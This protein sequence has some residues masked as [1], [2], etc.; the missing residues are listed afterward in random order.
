M[1]TVP[2]IDRL[3]S[4]SLIASTAAWSAAF[5]SPRPIQREAERAAATGTRAASHAR[6]RSI[7]EVLGMV[8]S[9]FAAAFSSEI[10][11]ADHVRRFEHGIERFDFLKRAPH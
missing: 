10:F 4:A 11:D 3:F 6:L 7:F 1:T 8:S 5:S 2:A 9:C